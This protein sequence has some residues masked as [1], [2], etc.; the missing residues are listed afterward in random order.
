[1]KAIVVDHI[2]PHRGTRH[3]SGI[4]A[5]GELCASGAMSERLGEKIRS[6]C[7]VTE[8]NIALGTVVSE[9]NADYNYSIICCVEVWE[10]WNE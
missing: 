4:G 8:K 10:V 1:M 6:R 2:I 3:A 9:E 7:T 5:T